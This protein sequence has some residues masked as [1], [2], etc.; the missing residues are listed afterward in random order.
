MRTSKNIWI[1]EK[2]PIFD[3]I[4]II[5]AICIRFLINTIYFTL[6]CQ[7]SDSNTFFSVSGSIF[8]TFT[9]LLSY[10]LTPWSRVLLEKL[11]GSVASQEI[12]RIFGTR[13]FPTV[14]TIARHPSLSWANS[15]QS[16]PVP[17][18]S[19]RSLLILSS[20]LRLG[21]PSG[22]RK[23]YL[24]NLKRSSALMMSAFALRYF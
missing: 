15:I 24:R 8:E 21:L 10:L 12:P 7:N 1:V 3:V 18:A 22:I 17:P 4:N 13:K 16:P 2:H 5:R 6:A 19:W 20:H 14:P 23:V 9:Y 11:P